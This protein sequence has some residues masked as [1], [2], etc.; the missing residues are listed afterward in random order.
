MPLRLAYPGVT[1]A[2]AMPRLP[3][4]SDRKDVEILA[5]RH[6]IMV[7]ERQLHGAKVR[8]THTDRAF[9]AAL[10]HRLP[11]HR[12]APGPTAG[13]PHHRAAPAPRPDHPASHP[14][15]SSQACRPAAHGAVHPHAGI[16]PGPK[17]QGMG[18]PAHPR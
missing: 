1:N 3:P 15:I 2:L 11:H 12:A 16:T 14:P 17:E 8:F 5:P 7:G 4:M 9:P 18:P 10:L 13:T 6:Q